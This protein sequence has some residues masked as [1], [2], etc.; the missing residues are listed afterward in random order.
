MII[1]HKGDNMNW[2]VIDM[3]GRFLC[4]EGEQVRF[5]SYVHYDAQKF[6]SQAAAA[7]AA[8]RHN[9]NVCFI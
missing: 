6:V 1:D 8:R 7:H 4:G 9:A 3:A 2:Y 5:S